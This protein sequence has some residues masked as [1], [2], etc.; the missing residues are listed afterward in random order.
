MGFVNCFIFPLFSGDRSK[1]TSLMSHG[2]INTD[3]NQL[4]NSVYKFTLLVLY[5]YLHNNG[6]NDLTEMMTFN[7]FGYAFC[8]SFTDV[9][10]FFMSAFLSSALFLLINTFW[11][12]LILP[13]IKK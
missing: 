5:D 11:F 13:F 10:D 9:T 2:W 12:L 3:A 7:L 4:M 6:L 8:E 1:I